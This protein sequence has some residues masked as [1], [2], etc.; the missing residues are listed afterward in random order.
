MNYMQKQSLVIDYVFFFAVFFLL[1]L[2][3]A[4]H[5][6][7]LIDIGLFGHH[8]PVEGTRGIH[9]WWM[10][11]AYIPLAFVVFL[12]LAVVLQIRRNA[13][14]GRETGQE[15]PSRPTNGSLS[16]GGYRSRP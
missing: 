12:P 9:Y 11:L 7:D 16:A 13:K 10:T 2:I 8:N 1:W 5:I 3:G 4:P 15:N 14:P 6:A